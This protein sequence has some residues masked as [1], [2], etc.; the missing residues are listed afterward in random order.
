M[1]NKITKCNHFIKAVG[2]AIGK[3][4]YTPNVDNTDY[5]LFD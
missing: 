3:K 1:K 4:F 2:N 5:P